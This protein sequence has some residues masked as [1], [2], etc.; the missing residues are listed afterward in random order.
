MRTISTLLAVLLLVSSSDVLFAQSRRS[1]SS[2]SRPTYRMDKEAKDRLFDVVKQ[3]RGKRASLR[4]KHGL[5]W[6]VTLHG[7]VDG[8]IDAT[9]HS[10]G[11]RNQ[12]QAEP[13]DSIVVGNRVV[14]EDSVDRHRRLRSA[15]GI[16]R[17]V[18]IMPPEFMTTERLRAL[19]GERITVLSKG[20]KSFKVKAINIAYQHWAQWRSEGGK[21]ASKYCI[22]TSNDEILPSIDVGRVRAI[23]HKGAIYDIEWLYAAEV[24]QGQHKSIVDAILRAAVEQSFE[25]LA[26]KAVRKAFPGMSDA[27]AK[28]AVKIGREMLEEKENGRTGDAIIVD[29]AAEEMLAENPGMENATG[30]ATFMLRV[31]KAYEDQ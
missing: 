21:P 23:Y 14:F 28:I 8:K 6:L 26:E 25:Y 17:D 22:F 7:V 12:Y 13:I 24:M 1:N 4:L 2:N 3:S 31:V 18:P 20:D 10:F 19:E 29:T 27:E 16:Y 15:L 5:A 11:D 30:V 9:N